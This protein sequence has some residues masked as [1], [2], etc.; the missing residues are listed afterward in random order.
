MSDRGT[1]PRSGS[2]VPLGEEVATHD[3]QRNW[4]REPALDGDNDEKGDCFVEVLDK[5]VPG[6][7]E[8]KEAPEEFRNDNYFGGLVGLDFHI[9]ARLTYDV[10]YERAETE[11]FIKVPM[12]ARTVD[13]QRGLTTGPFAWKDVRR[14]DW[15]EGEGVSPT[16]LRK[17]FPG[18]DPLQPPEMGQDWE[19]WFRIFES[20]ASSLGIPHAYWIDALPHQVS[21][22][23]RDTVASIKLTIE[24]RAKVPKAMLYALVRN[25]ILDNQGE[26]YS[27]WSYLTR[28]MRIPPGERTASE[29]AT[30]IRLLADHYEAARKRELAR[31]HRWPEISW[32]TLAMLYYHAL[33]PQ[34]QRVTPSPLDLPFDYRR[35]P[36]EEIVQRAERAEIH[37]RFS[38]ESGKGIMTGPVPYHYR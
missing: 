34:T 37:H 9:T 27:A 3:Q 26:R 12:E 21:E 23:L 6:A 38:R 32:Y 35:N 4:S 5:I 30:Y 11:N 14:Q 13:K 28:L 36:Y 17:P 10:P 7:V 33:S 22:P 29:L 15:Q 18:L 31:H 16:K 1:M 20:Q 24:E 8:K 25:K 2:I 19:M